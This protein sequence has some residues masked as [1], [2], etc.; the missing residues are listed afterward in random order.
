MLNNQSIDLLGS[1]ELSKS[2]ITAIS[3]K[4]VTELETKSALEVDLQL[5]FIEEIVKDARG[6]INPYVLKAVSS[7][8]EING[9]KIA[10]KN[11]YAQLDYEQDS[12]YLSLKNALSR[13][14][15]WLDLSFKSSEEIVVDSEIVPKVGVKSY[16]KDSVTY[17]FKK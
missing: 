9:C 15:E 10:Y 6:K 7:N 11:G 12:E 13:R 14:K 2:N 5:K 8:T 4:I 17:A 16:T 3:N 1:K